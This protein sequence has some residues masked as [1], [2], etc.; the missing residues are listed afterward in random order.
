MRVAIVGVGK[1]KWE[2]KGLATVRNEFASSSEAR[3]HFTLPILG[4]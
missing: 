3:F 4:G 2:A 1:K